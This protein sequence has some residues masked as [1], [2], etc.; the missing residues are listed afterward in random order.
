MLLCQPMFISL[1]KEESQGLITARRDVGRLLIGDVGLEGHR[2]N[3]IF[4][5]I[6][7]AEPVVYTI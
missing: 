4:R 1:S 6:M 2:K 5:M 7:L 3:F